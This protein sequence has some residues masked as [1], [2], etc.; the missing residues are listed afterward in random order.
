MIEL[1]S[2]IQG[3]HYRYTIDDVIVQGRFGDT[4]LAT[5]HQ[6][7]QDDDIVIVKTIELFRRAGW[8]EMEAFERESSR[9]RQMRNP[10]VGR[11]LDH[12]LIDE[13]DD[14]TILALVEDYVS[15]RS[16][17]KI[18]EEDG[19]QTTTEAL[20]W[21]ETMLE[22]LVYLHHTQNPPLVHGDIDPGNIIVQDNGEVVLVDFATLRQALLDAPRLASGLARGAL[23]FAPMEQLLGLIFPASDLYALAMSFL[24]CVSGQHP[25]TFAIKEGMRID[26]AS[27]LPYDAPDELAVLLKQMTEPDPTYRLNHARIAL[28]RIRAIKGTK[29]SIALGIT[30]AAT[31]IKPEESPRHMPAK[32]KAAPRYSREEVLF[33]MVHSDEVHQDT[34]TDE[35]YWPAPKK[36]EASRVHAMGINIDG[37]HMLLA[38]GHDALVLDADD[39]QV[40]GNLDFEELARKIAISRNGKRVAVLTGFEALR[41]YDADVSIWL[42]HEI[43]VDGM[44]PGNSQLTFSPDGELVAISDD[45][46]VNVYRWDD[47]SLV[48]R[49]DIDGQFGLCFEPSGQLLFAVGAAQTTI[50]DSDTHHHMDLDGVCFSPDGLQLAVSRGNVIQFG[51]FHGL[52]PTLNW[53]HQQ[54]ELKQAKGKT[55]NMLAFSP[56]Q[57]YLL[58]ATSTGYMRLIDLE[59]QQVMPW[60]D[61]RASDCEHVKIFSVGFGPEST[62]VL[63]HG[64]FAPNDYAED[65]IGCVVSWSIPEGDFLGSLLWLDGRLNVWGH[66]GFY[67]QVDDIANGGFSTREWERPVVALDA[68]KGHDPE[69]R[70]NDTDRARLHEY[71]LRRQGLH[72]LWQLDDEAWQLHPV[73]DATAGILP[74]MPE[75]FRRAEAIE[76]QARSSGYDFMETTTTDCLLEAAQEL[77][78][79][80]DDERERVH[81]SLKSNYKTTGTAHTEQDTKVQVDVEGWEDDEA[82][83]DEARQQDELAFRSIDEMN[84]GMMPR[85]Q[86]EANDDDDRMPESATERRLR[87]EAERRD[88]EARQPAARPNTV[89]AAIL[90]LAVGLGLSFVSLITMKYPISTQMPVQGM[91]ILA[92]APIIALVFYVVIGKRIF[93]A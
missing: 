63:A 72:T 91:I 11:Y 27:M 44:W 48:E 67:G 86:L 65:K 74:L 43:T 2:T 75:V 70:L 92:A 8:E 64:T 42:R 82:L 24:T 78:D 90:S 18:L 62:H 93:G 33:K 68:F 73:I 77:Q 52:T 79:M 81:R 41:L 12:A 22:T 57:R 56:N 38:Q 3:K 16:L 87:K 46:Q 83:I 13:R 4:Y 34:G 85:E 32:A 5:R 31:D 29:A 7:D 51:T 39:F 36:M 45:D 15:G 30:P 59:T 6:D 23:D 54:I 84:D 17:A 55:F 53:S 71:H 20:K 76:L 35:P 19:P 66:N 28:E 60:R 26:V 80:R 25:S 14:L 49:Y 50:I 37:T 10:H 58:A 69:K 1:Q 88:V 21:F 89:P 40:K 47:G 9:L 61:P